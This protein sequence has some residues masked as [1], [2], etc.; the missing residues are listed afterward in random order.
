[1]VGAILLIITFAI[2]FLVVKLARKETKIE[3]QLGGKHD[4]GP[5]ALRI[6]MPSLPYEKMTEAFYNCCEKWPN[7]GVTNKEFNIVLRYL[8]IFNRFEYDD[9]DGKCLGDLISKQNNTYVALIHGH[10]TVVKNGKIVDSIFYQSL[11][12]DTKIYCSWKFL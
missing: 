4:C 11:K 3:K 6:V 2:I 1:M 10:F 7:A 12:D 9:A 8:N 5:R